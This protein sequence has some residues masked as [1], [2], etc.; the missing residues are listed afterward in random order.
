MKRSIS[1]PLALFALTLLATVHADEKH[2]DA[3]PENSRPISSASMQELK[4]RLSWGHTSTQ[5]M[6]FTIR[7]V[8][9][10]PTIMIRDA[11][12]FSLEPGEGLRDGFWQSRAGAGDVDGVEFM[13]VYPQGP[14]QARRQEHSIWKH[15][16]E[17]SDA[18]TV[19]RLRNDPAFQ[20]DPLILTVQMDANATRGFS[21]SIQQLALNRALWVPEL[22]VFV[23]AGEPFPTFLEH[24]QELQPWKG[25]RTLDRIRHE[26]EASYEQYAALW[27][28]MGNPKRD[29]PSHLVGVS[30]DSAIPKFGIDRLAGVS[31]DLGNPD[32]LGFTFDLGA[33]DWKKQQLTDALPVINTLFERDG[34]RYEI[35][36]F[37]Y[38]LD[39][40]PQERRGDI[41]MVLLQKVKATNLEGRQRKVTLQ[42]GHRRDFP[43]AQVN[44]SAA[45]EGGAFLIEETGSHHILM[46]VEAKAS[47]AS[48]REGPVSKDAKRKVFQR[49]M[50]VS[51]PL[52]LPASSAT[53]L[54]VKLPSPMAKEVDRDKLLR[55]DYAIARRSTLAFWS[56]YL[57]RGAQFEVPEKA[58]NDLFRANLWHA[59]RLPR[60]HG[61]EQPGIQIDLPYSNF[62]Y[63]QTGTPWPVNQAV[64]VDY[65][66]YD[67]RGHHALALE[68]LLAIYR[69]NQEADGRV[70]GF[71]NWG[72]YTPSMLYASAKHCLLSHDRAGQAALLPPTLR[73]LDWCLEELKRSSGGD[74]QRAAGG[75]I[76]A[77]LNDLSHEPRAWA[78]NQAY[79]FA[80][81]DL[82]GQLLRQIDHSRAKECLDA[83]QSLR[84]AIA[85]NFGNASMRSPLVQLKDHTWMPYVPC[86]ALTPRRLFE[87]W[88]PT[89]IDTGA[90]H[91]S[92]LNALDPRGL[93]TTCLLNDHEDNLFLKGWGMANEPVYNQQASVYLLRDDPEAAIRSFYSYMACA[94]S[95]SVLEPVEHRWGW[96]QFFGPPS[97]D[98]AWFELY[99]NMLVQELNDDTLLLGQATPRAW[100]K[101]GKKIKVQRAPTCYG[102]IS[103][104]VDSH[105]GSG[106]IAVTLDLPDEY[107][108]QTLLVR[109]RHPDRKLMQSIT[110]NGVNWMNFDP[111][112][113]WVRI[114]HPKERHY[115]I[116]ASY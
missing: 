102:P 67:L 3:P 71:A 105:A 49:S 35:E 8:P 72:V 23:T 88:Y 1:L 41:A 62:A 4:V 58:V 19:N 99:R 18:D 29:P 77:P 61:G 45:T 78:F 6:P 95:H 47:E 92:R 15:F 27:A 63:G 101:E 66:L 10:R 55:L 24:Q 68:E 48:F 11:A 39:G 9:S 81:L 107:P 75:L 113:E 115:Q 65:M 83:S 22:D 104:T 52:E 20:I 98:G 90:L 31:S 42:M 43:D 36:Q 94:F 44:F 57:A 32:Q 110:V 54:I 26:P 106:S 91:L 111:A 73:A 21:V 51:V 84:E 7:L 70:G 40:P 79:M 56:D 59:L 69:N 38:P 37:A 16:L 13:L 100:L 76:S 46:S 30:W 116:V 14:V 33:A 82:L 85:R 114:P 86:D 74:G 17:V 89:D 5:P 25:K 50:N 96:G 28:D 80:G 103:W 93:L 97:T 64:Y 60:R 109:V 12:G 108:P 87:Q 53:E 112:R 2:R 34:I